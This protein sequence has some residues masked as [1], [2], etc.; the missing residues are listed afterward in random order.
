MSLNLWKQQVNNK[1]FPRSQM[2]YGKGIIN[3]V[4]PFFF[5]MISGFNALSYL[6]SEQWS[7]YLKYPKQRFTWIARG[8][9]LTASIV[10]NG[11]K[12]TLKKRS[13]SVILFF[14]PIYLLHKRSLKFTPWILKGRFVSLFSEYNSSFFLPTFKKKYACIGIQ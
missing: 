1:L 14:P 11:Y 10:N 5:C 6:S 4:I 9:F 3:N 2:S 12:R 7:K 13:W 8:P